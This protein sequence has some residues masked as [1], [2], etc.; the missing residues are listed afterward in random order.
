MNNSIEQI[1]E[2]MSNFIELQ[3]ETEL[4][5]DVQQDS[6]FFELFTMSELEETEFSFENDYELL[7]NLWEQEVESFEE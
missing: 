2:L 6:F 5:E 4:L 3:I 7:R 1:K